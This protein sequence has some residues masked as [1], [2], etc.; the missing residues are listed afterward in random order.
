[1]PRTQLASR[2]S[3]ADA[4][5]TTSSAESCPYILLYA[6]M[7]SPMRSSSLSTE[8][9]RCFPSLPHVTHVESDALSGG[10]LLA[11]RHSGSL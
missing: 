4:S 1:M 11:G 7:A 10:S 3:R 6:S 2:P 9:S 8:E 5:T